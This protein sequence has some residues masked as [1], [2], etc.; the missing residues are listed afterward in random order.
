MPI[1]FSVRYRQAG[2]VGPFQNHTLI[3]TWYLVSH[4][5]RVVNSY[6]PYSAVGKILKTEVPAQP[7]RTVVI[8]PRIPDF[9]ALI[10]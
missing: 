8:F 9:F 7:K 3:Q 5:P 2:E 1:S 4:L 10:R 6:H